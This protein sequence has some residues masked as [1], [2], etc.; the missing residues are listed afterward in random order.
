VRALVLACAMLV[1]ASAP[2]H[3]ADLFS[4]DSSGEQ[5]VAPSVAVDASGTGY[6]AWEHRGAGGTSS[7]RYCRVPQGQTCASPQTL[8][9]PAGNGGSAAVLLGSGFTVY[10]VVSNAYNGSS[11]ASYVFTSTDGGQT[12]TDA[13]Q[14][15]TSSPHSPN[16]FLLWGTNVLMAGSGGGGTGVQSAALAGSTTTEATLR[17]ASDRDTAIGVS[18]GGAPVVADGG[19][20]PGNHVDVYHATGG[21]PNNAA[22]WAG[23]TTLGSGQ[24]VSLAT[25]AGGLFLTSTD[26][27]GAISVRKYDDGSAQ[28]GQPVAAAQDPT[29]GVTGARLFEQ[30]GSGALILVTAGPKRSDGTLPV[31][32]YTST[33][34]STFL[35][36]V[37]VALSQLLIEH[38]TLRLA[39]NAGGQGFIVFNDGTTVRVADF[40]QQGA[41]LGGPPA[42]GCTVP[43]VRRMTIDGASAAITSAG[44]TVAG[45]RYG[46]ASGGPVAFEHVYA[47]SPAAGSHGSGVTEMVSLSGAA[48]ASRNKCIDPVKF[49]VRIRQLTHD[50][51]RR[52]TFT[53]KNVEVKVTRHRVTASDYRYVLDLS[54]ALDRLRAQTY[55]LGVKLTISNGQVVN[56]ISHKTYSASCPVVIDNGSAGVPVTS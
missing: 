45:R 35:G 47:T 18:A 54:H 32:A 44:C 14:L 23:P 2:A 25:G 22:N 1:G 7:T 16:D 52:I 13:R 39:T 30:P 19:V 15:A 36:P 8:S 17:D 4:L 11:F 53:I 5:L 6:F 56:L 9:S 29:S 49:P 34:G 28:F 27:T 37:D 24:D 21:D 12:F 42:S 55:R 41:G 26:T 31:R 50:S 38:Q 43:A 20:I 10:V 48:F 51:F 40:T 46:F 3:A 33:D